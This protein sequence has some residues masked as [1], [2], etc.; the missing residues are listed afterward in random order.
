MN[1]FTALRFASLTIL[2]LSL[3]SCETMQ[4]SQTGGDP[5]ASNYGTDGGYNPYPGQSGYGSSGGSVGTYTPPPPPI[6]QSD[7]YAFSPPAEP[8]PAPAPSSSSRSSS[9]AS[10]SSSH[11]RYTVKK[12]DTLYSLARKNGTSVA[13]IKSANGMSS[14]LIRIGQTLKIP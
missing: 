1:T 9:S 5:Y 12:G 13:K 4:N 10:S 14:D 6:P 7:P 2:A 8:T 3:S 11:S